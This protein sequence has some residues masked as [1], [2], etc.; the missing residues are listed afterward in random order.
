V[1]RARAFACIDAMRPI[2]ERRGVSVARIALAWLLHRKVV[3]SVIIGA[4]RLDQL[5]DNIA[6][7]EI[8]LTGE[9][10]DALDQ[11]SALPRE[12]PGWMFETQGARGKLLAS[13]G[14]PNAR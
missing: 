7:T 11:A 1:D 12:Y 8:E 2:A 6:A 3:S 13:L 14:R 9:E 10:L 5:D 4:K